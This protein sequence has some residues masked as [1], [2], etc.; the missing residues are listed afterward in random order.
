MGFLDICGGVFQLSLDNSSAVANYPYNNWFILTL[1]F[2]LIVAILFFNRSKK[3][4]FYGILVSLSLFAAWKH[5]MAREDIFHTK[6]L[7][8]YLIISLSVF[9]IFY[10]KDIWLK[11][12]LSVLAVFLFSINMKNS[13]NNFSP[14]YELCKINNFYEFISEFKQLKENSLNMTQSQIAGKKLPQKILDTI[15]N[16]TV[17]VYPWDYSIIPA[18]N[19]KWQPRVVLHS[20][21][22]YT[23][24]LDRKN[25]E[26][27]SSNKSPEYLFIEKNKWSNVNG[28]EFTSIDSRYFLN[29][30]PNTIL[31]LIQ[32]YDFSDSESNFLMLKR[33]EKTVQVIK[34]EI[35]SNVV[36]W[37]AW[38]DVPES[39]GSLMRA[40]LNFSKSFLER[41]KS[42]VYKDEQFWIYLQLHNGSI[43]KYRIV[44]KNAVDG[45]W[46]NPYL[47]TFDKA[48]SVDKILFKC[49]N[50][51][52]L[53]KNL[54]VSWEQIMFNEPDRINKFFNTKITS[55]SVLYYSTIDYENPGVDNW[56]NVN[57]NAVTNN[58]FEGL[59]SQ[60]I[61]PNGISSA[62]TFN[63]DSI[64]FQ[65][66]KITADCWVKSPDYKLSKDISLILLIDDN[67]GN[68][69]KTAIPIDDQLT[70]GTQWNNIFNFIDYKHYSRNCTFKSYLLNKSSKDVLVDNFRIMIMNATLL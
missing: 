29:D 65:D 45:I 3:S 60:L 68:I 64:L 33:R 7:Y 69:I 20:Y 35:S 42:F 43:H 6:G 30:E 54:T 58:S 63:M 46:I 51:S 21:A 59:K 52:I 17:D 70:D 41:V 12:V 61:K 66:L 27:F 38:I 5:G 39:K 55:D 50:Q 22:S 34:K 44:P 4:I 25:A 26:H 37:G 56:T 14:K 16:S 36:T 31:S 48:Y 18:N 49:S 8:I 67:K 32:N 28:G 10:K 11:L 2:I 62:F 40:K 23:S 13:I 24:W 47:F 9:I 53:V 1:L 15:S 57:S 19:L